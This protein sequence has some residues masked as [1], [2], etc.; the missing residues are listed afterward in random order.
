MVIAGFAGPAYL[1]GTE[2]ALKPMVSRLFLWCGRR[3]L[4][5]YSFRNTPLKRA[6]MPIPPQPRVWV[7]E[8]DE[9][10]Y[11]ESKWFCQPEKLRLEGAARV[12][13]GFLRAG[14]AGLTDAGFTLRI[15]WGIM[16]SH[17]SFA[18]MGSALR[19]GRK[20]SRGLVKARTARRMGNHPG[21]AG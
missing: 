15:K 3:D 10:Y 7:Y 5:P 1:S 17:I 14:R 18:M 20:A 13:F 12:K 8:G 19:A 21:A 6:R 9:G 11:T 16:T 4:N 2:K